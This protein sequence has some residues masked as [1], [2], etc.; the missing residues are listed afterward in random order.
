MRIMF[1]ECI[2]LKSSSLEL[3]ALRKLSL[4]CYNSISHV[5]VDIH[6]KRSAIFH[7]NKFEMA[8]RFLQVNHKMPIITCE[9]SNSPHYYEL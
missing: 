4:R 2:D 7:I 8:I 9:D 1:G 5:K 6:L 3:S